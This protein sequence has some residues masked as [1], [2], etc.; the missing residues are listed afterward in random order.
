MRKFL[1]VLSYSLKGSNALFFRGRRGGYF[2]VL[3]STI[4]FTLSF[5]FPVYLINLEGF[6]RISSLGV[7][8]LTTLSISSW[9]FAISLL[10]IASFSP[11]LIYTMRFTE[12]SRFLM[13]LPLSKFS[14]AMNS[15]LVSLMSNTL[16]PIAYIFGMM[17]Y[18]SAVG[19]STALAFISSSL[20]VVLIL[21]LSLLA[22][23]ILLRISGP[24]VK[25]LNLYVFLLDLIILVVMI[26]LNPV[27]LGTK[28]FA[29]AISKLEFMMRVL[30]SK[31][32]PF[33][34]PVL[35]LKDPIYNFYTIVLI[36]ASILISR[37]I[38]ERMDLTPA[39]SKVRYKNIKPFGIFKKDI[40]MS[41]R[42]EQFFFFITYPLVFSVIYGQFTKNPSL[43]ISI[44][45]IFS[46]FYTSVMA[47]TI[48]QM[49]ISTD[50]LYR[51]YPK[52]AFE[53]LIPKILIP[54]L[55]YNAAN[56]GISIYSLSMG[57]DL[58]DFFKV[59]MF[60]AISYVFASIMGVREFLKN[61]G[62]GRIIL[63][64]PSVLKVEF[65]SVAFVFFG[66]VYGL[67]W[68]DGGGILSKFQLVE[69][70]IVKHG[71]ETFL[72]SMIALST[73]WI[74]ESKRIFEDS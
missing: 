61:P 29:E 42:K 7:E 58:K 34:W 66:L 47:A 22:A 21:S 12:E 5:G 43:M 73:A 50:P 40:K 31:F 70:F 59:L 27:T 10:S 53:I 39:S 20:N 60:M 19:S 65:F 44:N 33:Y 57:L 46:I 30:T 52:R 74:F 38:S 9:S 18:A 25:R 17:G 3:F 36:L 41:L 68:K 23:L 37:N 51:T 1:L 48:T 11:H 71:F 72:V 35:A 49:E 2:P 54:S 67:M 64:L 45:S 26:Q 62:R 28:R 56:L 4:F 32:N 55:I 14:L 24:G 16:L 8:K 15:L 69:R 13:T 6:R 63:P